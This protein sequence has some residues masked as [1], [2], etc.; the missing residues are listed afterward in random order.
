MF[1]I[2]RLDIPKDMVN[3]AM[4]RNL[5]LITAPR[6]EQDDDIEYEDEE[7]EVEANDWQQD[8][9]LEEDGLLFSNGFHLD[10]FQQRCCLEDLSGDED[11]GL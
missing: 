7:F 4:P 10:R 5:R 8:T 9:A 2:Q 3:A 11:D 1:D 6:E